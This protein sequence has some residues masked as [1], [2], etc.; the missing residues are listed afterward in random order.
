MRVSLISPKQQSDVDLA[1]IL[2]ERFFLQS[3]LP[4]FDSRAVDFLA[5]L[6]TAVLSK[7]GI[8]AYPEIVALAHWLRRAHL[9][10]MI[11]EFRR[12]VHER[13]VVAPRGLA[14]H[15][16]PSNVDS[17][18][19]YSW[20]LS[21]IAGNS[22][23]VRLSQRS[24]DQL[25]ILLE[26]LRRVFQSSDWNDLA[27]RNIFMTYEHESEINAYLSARSDIRILWGGN[28]TIRLL[29]AFPA[30]P[31]TLDI[32]LADKFSYALVDAASYLSMTEREHQEMAKRFF[33]DA[34]WF[35]QM[36]CSSP[37]LVYFVGQDDVCHKA[38]EAFWRCNNEELRRRN[39]VDSV[40]IAM[41]KLVFVTEKAARGVV[42]T[43]P[44][45]ESKPLN[46]V[47]TIEPNSVDQCRDTCGGGFFF[48]SFV[49]SL[50]QVRLAAREDDQTVSYV[51]FSKPDLES[52]ARSLHGRGPVRIVPFGQAL[53]FGP[54]WDG[55]V[56]FNE[57]TKRIYLE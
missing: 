54:T 4:P 27:A 18:F 46:S 29:R 40:G 23:V 57:L 41:N 12:T 35:D 55:F 50:D 48:Q 51:G 53:T 47:V 26:E 16:A 10:S 11:S 43:A 17:I 3:C 36:A 44:N 42:L 9:E 22:N 49:R 37:R 14:F 24:N 6:S 7:S 30:K 15:V 52:Y 33:N 31:T 5:T 19:L 38:S 56:L 32:A 45:G 8:E 34:Y 39:H 25:D 1:S 13:H 2:D 21:L 28:E 20:S